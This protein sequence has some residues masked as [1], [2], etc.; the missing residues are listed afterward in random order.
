MYVLVAAIFVLGYLA[1]VFEHQLGIAELHTG[2]YLRAVVEE[3]FGPGLLERGGERGRDFVHGLV[4]AGGDDFFLFDTTLDSANNVD[5][6][7]D[8][9]PGDRIVLITGT[10][11]AASRHN[12]VVV[13]QVTD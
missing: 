11:T 12:A 9:T 10:G 3:H 6:I 2:R 13:H 1:I 8:F 5:S 7:T 4:F